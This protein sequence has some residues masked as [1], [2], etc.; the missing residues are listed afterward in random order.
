MDD[1]QTPEYTYLGVPPILQLRSCAGLVLAGMAIRAEVGMGN[2]EEAVELLERA[3]SGN[4]PTR[5]RFHVVGG[6]VVAE[7]DER[8]SGEVS[9]ARGWRTV[10]EL[11]S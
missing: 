6:K 2:L 9:G 7:V 4:G 11:A 8:D 1:A 5:Y 3:H 10:V